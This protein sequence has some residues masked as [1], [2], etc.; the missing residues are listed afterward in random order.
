VFKTTSGWREQQVHETDLSR[1]EQP[2]LPG[3]DPAR[4]CVVLID[5]GQLHGGRAL[6]TQAGVD[7][8]LFFD[9]HRE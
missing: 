4:P 8:V 5:E 6:T 7:V 3:S 1:A 2:V 9:R